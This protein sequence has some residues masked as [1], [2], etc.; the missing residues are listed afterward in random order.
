M[1]R[2]FLGWF[3]DGQQKK[4]LELLERHR[5][6]LLERVHGDERRISCLDYLIYQ[7]RGNGR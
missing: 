4:Q 1:I 7:V 5:E 6:H 2:E 3:D